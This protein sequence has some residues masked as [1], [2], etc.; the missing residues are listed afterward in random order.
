MLRRHLLAAL[1]PEAPSSILVH[2]HVLVDFIGAA[3]IGPGRYEAD[4][5]FR[6]ALPK[7][8]EIRALGCRRLLECTPEYLG[9]DPGLLARL[10]RAAGLEI[11]TNTGLYGARN[12]QHLPGYAQTETAT[13]LAQRWIAEYRGGIAG[14]KP[15]FIKIGVNNG[16]LHPLDRKLVAAA[17]EA[18]LATGLTIAVHTGNGRAALDQ[19]EMVQ[20]SRLAPAKWVWVHAQNETDHGVHERVARA[21]A[22]VEF[23]GIGPRTLEWNLR[24]VE[25]MARQGLLGRV[26]LSQDSGWYHVGE[27]GGGRYNGYSYIYTDFLPKLDR[28]WVRQLMWENPRRAF[29]R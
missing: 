23:D 1:A 4:E 3:G 18:S 24:A 6:I 20:A 21:G 5:V 27:P 25:H 8:R 9:R 11:W 13:Q 28:R 29:G 10:G 12:F 26:L 16:P 14:I 15:R 2:E 19:L 22:W 7:L 17:I